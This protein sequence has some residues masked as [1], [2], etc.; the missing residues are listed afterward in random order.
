MK[1]YK[2]ALEAFPIVEDN[3]KY[4]LGVKTLTPELL[5]EHGYSDYNEPAPEVVE[6]ELTDLINTKIRNERDYYLLKS[7]WTQVSDSPLTAE[8][9][10]EW[11]IYRQQL[12]DLTSQYLDL[13]KDTEI[14][15]P[16]KPV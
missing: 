4:L 7:D 11:A 3:I 12:R 1:L 15:W 13:T 9:K 2:K 16:T 10:E 14:L 6:V 8:K 5:K